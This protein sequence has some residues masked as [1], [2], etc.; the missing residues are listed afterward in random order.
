MLVGEPVLF[1]TVWKVI[2]N[3]CFGYSLFLF[4]AFP[5]IDK[6]IKNRTSLIMQRFTD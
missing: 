5:S 1:K 6:F 3:C 2:E 4:F